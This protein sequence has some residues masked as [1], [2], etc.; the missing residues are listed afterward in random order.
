[1][2]RRTLRKTVNESGPDIS[3]PIPPRMSQLFTLFP[4]SHFYQKLLIQEEGRLEVRGI[5]VPIH[6]PHPAPRPASCK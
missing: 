2:Q 1:M 6:L 5:L 4:L 3:S